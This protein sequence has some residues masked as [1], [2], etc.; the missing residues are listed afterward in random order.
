MMDFKENA[1]PFKKDNNKQKQ[2]AYI[3]NLN[4]LRVIVISAVSGALLFLVLALG[5]VL[6]AFYSGGKTTPNDFVNLNK[7][8]GPLKNV[9]SKTPKKSD[10][11]KDEKGALASIAPNAAPSQV[12]SSGDEQAAVNAPEDENDVM[13]EESTDP[14]AESQY[15]RIVKPGSKPNAQYFIQVLS[16]NNEKKIAFT[17]AKLRKMGLRTFTKKNANNTY[18][19]SVGVFPNQNEAKKALSKLQKSGDFSDAF[20]KLG[21]VRR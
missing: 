7:K 19:L 12:G 13:I 4:K 11:T 14:N 8:E 9:S 15:T 21:Y 2:Y 5:F 18:V 20:V 6:G 3:L 1:S 16:S 17:S 10:K